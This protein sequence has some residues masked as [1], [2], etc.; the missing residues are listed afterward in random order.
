[1]T[2]FGAPNNAVAAVAAAAA[3][4]AQQSCDRVTEL[5]RPGKG[6]WVGWGLADWGLAGLTDG[7]WL[8]GPQQ[9]CLAARVWYECRPHHLSCP[10]DCAASDCTVLCCAASQMLMDPACLY[11]ERQRLVRLVFS[12]CASETEHCVCNHCLQPVFATAWLEVYSRWMALAG[13]VLKMDGAGWR[14]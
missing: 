14:C 7:G 8:V 10:T 11:D 13:G 4:D 3:G 9:A 2:D 6:I 12:V 5:R 1:M